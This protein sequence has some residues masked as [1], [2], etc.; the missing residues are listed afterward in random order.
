[1]DSNYPLYNILC[2][3]QLGHWSVIMGLNGLVYQTAMIYI[4][5]VCA[6]LTADPYPGTVFLIIVICKYLLYSVQVV[7]YLLVTNRRHCR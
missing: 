4:Y 6:L 1:M 5:V 2:R 3:A 7:L